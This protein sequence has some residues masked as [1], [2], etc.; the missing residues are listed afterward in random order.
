MLAMS[1]STTS[2]VGSAKMERSR[3]ARAAWT[4][5]GLRPVRRRL[6]DPGRPGIVASAGRGRFS[7]VERQ[8]LPTEKQTQPSAPHKNIE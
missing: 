7:T 1:M 4:S 2:V 5:A 3:S 8:V 6:A